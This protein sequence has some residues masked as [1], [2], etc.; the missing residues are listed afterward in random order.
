MCDTSLI[1][2]LFTNTAIR[3]YPKSKRRDVLFVCADYL[4][5]YTTLVSLLF[6]T[7]IPT[8][9]FNQFK[10]LLFILVIKLISPILKVVDETNN[11]INPDLIFIQ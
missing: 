4:Y 11:N 5:I 2:L 1:L 8:P 10:Q 7:A 6:S 3:L 9:L